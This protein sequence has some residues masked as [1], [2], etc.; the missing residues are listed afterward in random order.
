MLQKPNTVLVGTA[1]DN[2]GAGANVGE[3]IAINAETGAGI[4]YSSSWPSGVNAIQ[5]ALKTGFRP[6]KERSNQERRC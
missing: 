5:L 3:V 2:T 6:E 4:N 1:V